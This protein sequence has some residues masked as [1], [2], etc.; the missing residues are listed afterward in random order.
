M[1]HRLAAALVAMSLLG[2]LLTATWLRPAAAGHGTHTQLGMLQCGWV[3]AFGRPCPTCGMTTAFTHAAHGNIARSFAVQPMGAVLAIAS[4]A[5]IWGAFHAAFFA[6][7]VGSIAG[8]L[9]SPRVLWWIAGATLAAW[10]YKL[11]TWPT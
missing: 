2:L 7:R 4:A 11:W 10:A 3:A 8:G 9:L 1:V 6:S 5:G